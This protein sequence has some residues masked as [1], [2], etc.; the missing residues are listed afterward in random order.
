[1]GKKNKKRRSRSYDPAETMMPTMLSADLEPMAR[2]LHEKACCGSKDTWPE[3]IANGGIENASADIRERFISQANK[4]MREAQN[5]IVD[6]IKKSSELS[7]SEEILFRG[8]ADSIAWQFLGHQLCHARR[9]FK[10]QAPPNLKHS[11]FDSVVLAAANIIESHSDSMPLLSD[12]T[13][14]VQVGDILANIPG[15]GMI[16]Y[17]VKEGKENERLIDFM[18]FYGESKCDRALQIFCEQSSPKSIKQLERM[19][20]QTGRMVHFTDVVSKGVSKDPDTGQLIQIP[21]QEVQ[22]DTWDKELNQLL[23]N[24]EGKGWGIQVIDDC[25]FIGC[26]FDKTMIPAGHI[27]FNG[28]FDSCGGTENCPRAR[29]FDSMKIPL[30]LPLFNRQIPHEKMFDLLF[31]RLQVCMG[32]NIESL[33]AQLKRAGL[34]VRFGTNRETTQ[35]EQKGGKVYRHKGKSIFISNGKVEMTVADGIFV[36]MLFHGQKPVSLIKEMLE[37]TPVSEQGHR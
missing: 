6:Q 16:I 5:L 7:A 28:W 34:Q 19:V 36:R 15:Q 13:S 11:N 12:L 25:L 17:E 24:P 14:F 10:E 30:A 4:G 35:L 18:N 32:V 1:M 26:Y 27:I 3:L 23:D 33:I 31:G 29:L 37:N 22:I 20:R 8:I 2:E 9:L 21:E